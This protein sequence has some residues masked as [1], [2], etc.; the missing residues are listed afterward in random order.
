M[1]K[2]DLK[3]DWFLSQDGGEPIPG[4]LPGCTYLDY[5]RNGMEDPFYGE[6][7]TKATELAHHDY[8]YSRTF[9]IQAETIAY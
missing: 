8:T 6:N 1:R 9:I 3:G 5:M 4:V 2:V 7:E